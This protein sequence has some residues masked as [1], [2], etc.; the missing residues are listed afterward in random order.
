MS[1]QAYPNSP[2]DHLFSTYTIFFIWV[3]SYEHSQ[4][5]GQQGKGEAIS[6][7]PLFHLHLP[8][9]DFRHWPDDYWSVLTSAHSL[10]PDADQKPLD[11]ERKSLN[12]KLRA[13]ARQRVRN[14]IF[15]ENFVYALNG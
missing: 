11:F 14:V 7:I 1:Y 13:C 3:F 5:T 8:H 10:Q 15:S 4:F 9:K 12:T 6:L 2:S